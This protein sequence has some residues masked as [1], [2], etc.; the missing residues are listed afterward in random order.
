MPQLRI[1]HLILQSLSLTVIGGEE[2]DYAQV[3]AELEIH[4]NN[5]LLSILMGFTKELG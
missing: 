3:P 5:A 2:G 4:V 1:K